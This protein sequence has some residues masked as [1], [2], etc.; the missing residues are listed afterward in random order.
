MHR[1]RF[2]QLSSFGLL[3]LLDAC[4]PPPPPPAVLNLAVEAGAD[5][6]P[7]P[8]GKALPVAVHLFELQSAAKFNRADVFAL[9]EHEKATLGE[10]DLFS[11]EFVISPGDKTTMTRM[12][13]PG[14]Q[15]V[16]VVVLFRD[17]DNATWRGVAPVGAS[18]PTNLKLTTNKIVATLAP[19]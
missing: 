13:K 7:D 16:G 19:A 5:Q 12:L 11:E 8:G 9:I 14:T 1:R 17:I 2:T 15:F 18:G 6:N 4:A 3:A 10:D